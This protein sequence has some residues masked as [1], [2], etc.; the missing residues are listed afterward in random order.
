[1][2]AWTFLYDD[3]III[4][5]FDTLLVISGGMVEYYIWIFTQFYKALTFLTEEIL[6]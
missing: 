6:V 1:M 3:K 2:L 4:K 5:M